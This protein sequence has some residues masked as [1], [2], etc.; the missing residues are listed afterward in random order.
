MG[1]EIRRLP[2]WEE[3]KIDDKL[4]III[5]STFFIIRKVR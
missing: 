4:E 5:F 3:S 2:K 1:I